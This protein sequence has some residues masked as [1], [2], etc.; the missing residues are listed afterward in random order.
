MLKALHDEATARGA[1]WPVVVAADAAEPDSKD[2]SR[3]VVLAA[4]AADAMRRQVL[5]LKGPALL[6]NPGLL[7]RYKLMEVLTDIA[8]GSGTRN[9]PP[10]LWLLVPQADPG[11]PRIDGVTLPV[12]SAANWA[13]LTDNWLANAHRAGTRSI[14]RISA[15]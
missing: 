3:L 4:K 11:M 7:A 10:S 8:Q 12:I 13:R 9:G 6:V 2:F 15:G 5:A 14:G 1:R